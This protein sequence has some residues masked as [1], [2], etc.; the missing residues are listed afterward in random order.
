MRF[1]CIRGTRARIVG[2]AGGVAFAVAA[3]G[4]PAAN[5]GTLL[6]AIS[7]FTSS[8]ACAIACQIG[9][10]PVGSGSSAYL[11][12]TYQSLVGALPGTVGGT[13]TLTS[14]SFTWSG[15]SP[16][17]AQ[18]Q[19]Q[20]RSNMGSVL[21]EGAPGSMTVNLVDQTDPANDQ[22]GVF[23]TTLS[24]S[25]PNFETVDASV[26]PSSLIPGHTYALQ[27]VEG[28]DSLLSVG[29]SASVDVG[30]LGL[31]VGADVGS[32]GAGS[33]GSGSGGSG[34]SV[35]VGANGSA[36]G[37]AGN[38]GTTVGAGTDWANV[39]QA[40]YATAKPRLGRVASMPAAAEVTASHPL[41]ITLSRKFALGRRLSYS[42]GGAKATRLAG[43]RLRVSLKQVGDRSALAVWIVGRTRGGHTTRYEVSLATLPCGAYLTATRLS[44]H[45]LVVTAY[46]TSSVSSAQ[47]SVPTGS[48]TARSLS[49]TAAGITTALRLHS[50]HRQ[51]LAGSGPHAIRVRIKHGSVTVSGLPRGVSIV[52]L[53]FAGANASS[54][55]VTASLHTAGGHSS[56]VTLS[57]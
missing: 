13:E 38:A 11:H 30:G 7:S 8:G 27:A 47:F 17:S 22:N 49:V 50:N 57:L 41:V 42:I 29:S 26:D 24:Q 56:R 35:G 39:C 54:G 45:R 44:G 55:S 9:A 46:S 31:N 52:S 48:G 23:N 53:G 10:T 34:G 15:Q 36:D 18:V 12:T 14:P 16:S 5:A 2:L 4:V 51:V 37:A 19:L 21:S 20:Y 28:L 33:G 32:G 25:Q 43:R 40:V 1:F 6:P 3:A